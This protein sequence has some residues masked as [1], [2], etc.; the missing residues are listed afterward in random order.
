[1]VELEREHGKGTFI[2]RLL[3]LSIFVLNDHIITMRINIC[4]YTHIAG[5]SLHRD[6]FDDRDH[7]DYHDNHDDD[8]DD[9]THIAGLSLPGRPLALRP[10]VHGCLCHMPGPSLQMVNVFDSF[11]NQS[12]LS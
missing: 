4:R 10:S 8:D 7:H 9:N 1:M 11:P 2:I 12:S 3:V 6:N 5:L